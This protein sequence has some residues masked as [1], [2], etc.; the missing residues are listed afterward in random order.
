MRTFGR[1]D[2]DRDVARQALTTSL[3]I[4]APIAPLF[5][6]AAAAMRHD[7]AFDFHTTFVPAARAVLD[8]A[9]PYSGVG[10]WAFAHRVAFVYP[11][12]AAYLYAPFT[13]LPGP[14]ASMVV[15]V[16]LVA[17]VP[18][19]LLILGVRDWRCHAI[20][21]LWLP[22]IGA[23]QTANATLPIVLALAVVWKRRDRGVVVTA[24]LAGLLIAIKLI[25]WPLLV[26]LLATRR[27]R[28]AGAAFAFWVALTA[29]PW[30][31]I[32]WAGLHRYPHL[33][34][35]VARAEGPDSY[36]LAGLLAPL[37]GSWTVASTAGDVAGIGV[38]LAAGWVGRRGRDRDALALAIAATLLLAPIVWMHYFAVLLVVVALYERRFGWAWTLPLVFWASPQMGNGTELQTALALATA[39]ATIAITVLRARELPP[40]FSPRLAARV[41]V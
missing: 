31:A 15:T 23:I 35:S 17:T 21:F 41:R 1:T 19:T 13:V 10:S 20:A 26:W 28:V 4:W 14:A 39:S 12:V 22:T 8:G 6:L 27:Y 29:L 30:A 25:F 7:F 33:L 34:T 37:T 32:G 5:V 38:L 40:W 11:P 24:F 16:L 36:S 18:A 9:S 2:S 3:A